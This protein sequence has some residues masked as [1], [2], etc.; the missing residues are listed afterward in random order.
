LTTV[1]HGE[2]L[3]PNLFPLIDQERHVPARH[4]GPQ[5]SNSPADLANARAL[6]A[7]LLGAGYQ[8]RVFGRFNQRSSI[9][10]NAESDRGAAERMANAF[11][12]ELT[13]ARLAVGMEK[14]E[15]T[16]SPRAAAQ[17]FLS[18]NPDKSLWD[19]QDRDRFQASQHRV[20]GRGS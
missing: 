19:P 13:A 5:G 12:A 17:R 3:S 20:L 18:P 14:S 10:A 2:I 1:G 16:L 8:R 6:E 9:E 4:R 7:T 11:D 15:R